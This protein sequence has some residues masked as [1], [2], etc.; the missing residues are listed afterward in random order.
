M[1]ADLTIALAQLNPTVGD[2]AG[3]LA[4]IRAARQKAGGAANIVVTGELAVSG[5]PPEDLV[6]KPAFLEMIETEVNQLAS[7]TADGGPALL[8]GAP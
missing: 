8:I 6:L 7:E 2:V 4:L 1:I 5:Y 3:N